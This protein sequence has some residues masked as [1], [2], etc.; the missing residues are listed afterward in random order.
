MC[1]R[2]IEKEPDYYVKPQDTLPRTRVIVFNYCYCI[3]LS[4]VFMFKVN[5]YFANV[6]MEVV[7][8]CGAPL[9]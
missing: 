2:L 5:L 3:E 1:E 8:V 6:H 9:N 7:F 4:V